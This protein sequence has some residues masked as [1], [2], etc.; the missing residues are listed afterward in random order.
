MA[1]V[2]PTPERVATAA[3][4][5]GHEVTPVAVVATPA[6]IATARSAGFVELGATTVA[7]L[8]ELVAA[9]GPGTRWHFVG[10]LDPASARLARNTVTLLHTL[11]STGLLDAWIKGPGT[12]P[13][14]LVQVAVAPDTAGVAPEAVG[15]LLGHARASGVQV[16]GLALE[17]APTHD[18]ATARLRFAEL[19]AL[20]DR[21]ASG[22][23]DLPV[24]AMGTDGDWESAVEQGS[25]LIRLGT[26]IFGSRR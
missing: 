13:A 10:D 23:G 19:R 5:A 12:A 9:A 21:L 26:T 2:I 15:S 22:P 24:L 14:V 1:G 11:D 17:A 7:A 16:R 25:T 20:R 3:A 4:R 8:P 6:D 18:A